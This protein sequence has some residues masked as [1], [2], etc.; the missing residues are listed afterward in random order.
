MN[1]FY[2]FELIVGSGEHLKQDIVIVMLFFLVAAQRLP[3]QLRFLT[4]T[5]EFNSEAPLT[6]NGFRIYYEMDSCGS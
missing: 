4:D 5:F 6:P 2:N 3:F 1:K